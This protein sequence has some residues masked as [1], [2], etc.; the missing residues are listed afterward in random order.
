[1]VWKADWK[2]ITL[3][4]WNHFRRLGVNLAERWERGLGHSS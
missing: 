1:M 2:G 4:V 3:E